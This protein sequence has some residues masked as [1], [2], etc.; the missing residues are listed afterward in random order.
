MLPGF[1]ITINSLSL[2]MWSTRIEPT[3]MGGSC[4]CTVLLSISVASGQ[5]AKSLTLAC[6]HPLG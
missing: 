3:V 1:E 6:H 5:A 2:S 4:L